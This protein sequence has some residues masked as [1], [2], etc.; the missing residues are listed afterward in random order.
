MKVVYFGRS[1]PRF[2]SPPQ[3]AGN[4]IELHP[5]NWDDYGHKTTFG[6]SCRI[7]GQD[8]NLG[9]LRLLIEKQQTSQ[10]YL[11]QLRSNGWNGEFPIPGTNYVSVPNELS[12]YEQLMA[13]LSVAEVDEI[14]RKLRDA[15]YLVNFVND[16]DAIALTDSSGFVNSLQRERGSQRAYS[17]AWKII[18]ERGLDVL[19]LGFRFRDVF[20]D[21]STLEFK[22][23]SIGLLPHDINVLIGPNGVGKSQLLLQIVKEWIGDDHK[24][25]PTGPDGFAERP[26][27]S[28]IVVVSY[29]PFEKFP[30]DMSAV[31]RQDTDAYR[32][33]GL[34][35]R[36]EAKA[37]ESRGQ[38]SLSLDAPKRYAAHSL[39][40]CLR[41]D[42]RYMAI[43][44]W[45][46]KLTTMES[47]LRTG[48]EFDF[49]AVAISPG[50]DPHTLY[51]SPVPRRLPHVVANIDGEA[52]EFVPITH[53]VVGA[54]KP[55]ALSGEVLATRGVFFFK[56]GA[57][58]EL[59]S[60]QRLFSFIVV[61]ILGVIRRGSLV[62]IDEPEL[63]LH[64]KL[65][66]QFID[67]LKQI[68]ARFSSKALLATHSIVTV[69]ET[70]A[71]CV[72]VMAR[73]D[74]GLVIKR[75]PFQTFGGDVQRIASYV[76]GDASESKP[77][78]R[79]I[80]ERL[81][82]TDAEMLIATL[83]HELNEELI[84]EIR[85]IANA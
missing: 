46:P 64:P 51:N 17:D 27:L 13:T 70:P 36:G 60:G 50:G 8:I 28:Q 10:L 75:P 59:S 74:E 80:A 12:F 57:L 66:I 42:E 71:D 31:A 33:F 21:L 43:R 41:E 45:E 48:F 83:G 56:N 26:N 39:I 19:D 77:F 18:A 58:V 47:V 20:G 78:Q 30:V 37:G 14:A 16:Q 34:R 44:D 29:S 52:M 5:N 1:A 49:A 67:M 24:I 69:R 72:H 7:D 76:F 6:V 81:K 68:L 63:F 25:G 11:D 62:L 84:V 2:A 79:W 40:S 32:Y 35:G 9:G 85:A 53:D 15:S 82:T 61:N 55:D 65:E 73:T 54:L 22:F 23:K 4:L 38:V 3:D